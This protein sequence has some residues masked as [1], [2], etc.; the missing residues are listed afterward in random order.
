MKVLVAMDSFKGS[1][2]AQEACDAVEKGI[3]AV[4]ENIEVIKKP[5]ADGGEGTV[6]TL[7]SSQDGK[8]VD[9]MVNDPLFRKIKGYYGVINKNTALM[10][11]AISSG[12]T[13]HNYFWLG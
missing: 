11:M 10:E 6:K 12:S 3:K 4:D 13:I 9:L 2:S 8:I 7:V 1:L 5:L